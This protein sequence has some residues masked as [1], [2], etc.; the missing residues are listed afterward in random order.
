MLNP[1]SSP[2][3]LYFL[4]QSLWL[5][6][7]DSPGNAGAGGLGI[8]PRSIRVVGSMEEGEDLEEEHRRLV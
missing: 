2:L 1:D 8:L 4:I 3:P 6:P 7:N 5:G